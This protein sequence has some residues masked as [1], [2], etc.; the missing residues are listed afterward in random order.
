MAASKAVV[1][2]ANKDVGDFR[3][4]SLNQRFDLILAPARVFEHAVSD[5]ERQAAFSGCATHLTFA[6][7]LAVHV[8]GPPVAPD[9][10]PPEKSRMIAPTP[11]HGTLRFSWRE[12]RDFSRESRTHCFRLEELDGLRRTWR[13]NPIEIRWYTHEALDVLGRNAGLKIVHRYR[14]FNRTP[15][16]PGSLH[17]IWVYRKA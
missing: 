16:E 6:G 1:V 14:D 7:T 8:W 12:E 10:A 5:S 9:P 2:D 17:M 11:E 4:L 13:H 15:F 3:N